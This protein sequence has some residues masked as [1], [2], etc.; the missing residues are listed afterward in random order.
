MIFIGKSQIEP[1]P[2]QYFVYNTGPEGSG[3]GEMKRLSVSELMH[4][5]DPQWRPEPANPQFLGVFRWNI[6]RDNE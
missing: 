1:G 3:T 2:E 4:F 5:P 6:L